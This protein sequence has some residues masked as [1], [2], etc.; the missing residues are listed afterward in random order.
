[1][2]QIL[3]GFHAISF[4]F[5]NTVVY[6]YGNLEPEALKVPRYHNTHVAR[7]T[8]PKFVLKSDKH[9]HGKTDNLRGIRMLE[10]LQ[11]LQTCLL[12]DLNHH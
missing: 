11:A 1:M 8:E 2:F 4:F 10:R 5:D 9:N 6:V 3:G 12:A 7:E